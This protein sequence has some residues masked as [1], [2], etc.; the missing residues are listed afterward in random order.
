MLISSFLAVTLLSVGIR[1]S[2]ISVAVEMEPCVGVLTVYMPDPIQ[3]ARPTIL[4]RVRCA[5]LATS[6]CHLT[7]CLNTGDCANGTLLRHRLKAG[8]IAMAITMTKLAWYH[9][10][11]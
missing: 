6:I 7:H 11:L 5:L 4:S 1:E 2:S 10:R 3:T 8:R 9:R